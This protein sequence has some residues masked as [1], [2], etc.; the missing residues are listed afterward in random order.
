MLQI[1]FYYLEI[2]LLVWTDKEE[3]VSITIFLKAVIRLWTGR[4]YSERTKSCYQ[5]GGIYFHEH[6]KAVVIIYILRSIWSL[7]AVWVYFLRFIF[8]CKINLLSKTKELSILLCRK[9]V[10]VLN[11][12]VNFVLFLSSCRI[13]DLT[14]L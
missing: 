4:A 14:G 5:T 8:S 2:Y 10:L 7:E 11:A 12:V 9:I 1:Q 3:R 6:Y 13:Q